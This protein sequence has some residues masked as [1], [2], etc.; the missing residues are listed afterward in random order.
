LYGFAAY[1]LLPAVQIMYRG[2]ARL[3]FSSASLQSINH[4]IA[5]PAAQPLATNASLPLQ[6]EI[7]LQG[8]RYA[9]PSALDKLILDGFDLVIPANASVGIT[10]RS[11]AG[12]STLMDILLGLLKPQ[13]G[14]LCVDGVQVNQDNA[15]DW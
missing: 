13:A 6:K 11:G 2:F 10:G 7:R 14:T 9:Y 3:R 15:A 1:R 5:L 12:K 4:D 8:I